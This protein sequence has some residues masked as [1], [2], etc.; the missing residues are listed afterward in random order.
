MTD[1]PP[2]ALLLAWPARSTSPSV[3]ALARAAVQVAS[4]NN[5]TSSALT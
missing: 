2:C 3:A 5:T 1:V 4:A